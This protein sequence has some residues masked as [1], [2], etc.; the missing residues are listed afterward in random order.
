MAD[1]YVTLARARCDVDTRLEGVDVTILDVKCCAG[2]ELYAGKAAAKPF[3]S[4]SSQNDYVIWAG[5]YGDS[6]CAG[7]QYSCNYALGFDGDGLG[8]G[9]AAKSSG[10]Q[11][12][13]LAA[14]CRFRNGAGKRFTWGGARTR[15]RVV[16]NSGYP[17]SCGLA[18]GPRARQA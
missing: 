16:A 9:Y 10:V 14:G 5:A 17:G 6:V 11:D 12:V 2:I 1:E 8:D 15:I 7:H 18:E 3:E 4:Q 13:D